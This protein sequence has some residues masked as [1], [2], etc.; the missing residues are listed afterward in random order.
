M[1]ILLLSRIIHC[2]ISLNSVCS[3]VCNPRC[4]RTFISTSVK[5]GVMLE[6]RCKLA[7]DFGS[8]L[9]VIVALH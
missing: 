7:I 5:C 2:M 9:S 1:T 3:M 4:T 6:H 8:E